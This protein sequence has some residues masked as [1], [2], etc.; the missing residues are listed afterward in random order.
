M[1]YIYSQL[2]LVYNLDSEQK[3]SFKFDVIETLVGGKNHS[4][5]I[6]IL[7]AAQQISYKLEFPKG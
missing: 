6:Q 1:L 2:K 3:D 7:Y 5:D 4:N